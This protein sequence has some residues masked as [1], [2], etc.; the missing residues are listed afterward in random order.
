MLL[1][2]KWETCLIYLFNYLCDDVNNRD[3]INVE[4][5]D[6]GFF[7]FRIWDS[8]DFGFRIGLSI[9]Q[10]AESKALKDGQLFIRPSVFCA[11]RHALCPVPCA[12]SL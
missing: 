6:L 11:M 10:R 1:R 9:G 4:I 2:L 3:G 8:F 7:R 12:L 5:S